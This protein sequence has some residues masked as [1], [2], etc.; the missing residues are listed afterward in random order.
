MR[1]HFTA[2]SGDVYMSM[3]HFIITIVIIIVIIIIIIIISIISVIKFTG[4]L[5]ILTQD[6]E[7]KRP[8]NRTP[9]TAGI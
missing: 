6:S 8:T 1:P 2:H 4:T 3:R 9:L 5:W 7:I